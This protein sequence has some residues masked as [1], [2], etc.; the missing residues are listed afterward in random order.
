MLMWLNWRCI[1]AIQELHL[2][3]AIEA[4]VSGFDGLISKAQICDQLFEAIK[5]FAA[6]VRTITGAFINFDVAECVSKAKDMC[7]CIHL[8]GLMKQFAEGAG[9]L[10]RSILEL[11]NC[12]SD[13]IGAYVLSGDYGMC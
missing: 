7:R 8:S 13:K 5:N 4:G 6:A 3:T 10:I 12:A 1:K 11:F 9:K 2:V